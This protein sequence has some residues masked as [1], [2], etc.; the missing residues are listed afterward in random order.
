MRAQRTHDRIYSV[1]VDLF[2]Y[3][4]YGGSSLRD[5]AEIAGINVATIYHHYASKLAI[6][7]DIIEVTLTDLADGGR[8]A[9]KQS[10]GPSASLVALARWHT[11]FHC[12][13][14]QEATITDREIN[15]VPINVRAREVAIR[16]SYEEMWRR[17]IAIGVKTSEFV[18]DDPDVSRFAVLT[19]CS[20]VAAWYNANGRLTPDE[21]ADIYGDLAL[22]LVGS[23]HVHDRRR[24][25]AQIL[26]RTPR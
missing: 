13:R 16:D 14:A 10:S 15:S 24:V 25:A 5:L 2:Y 17:V 21:I 12:I 6:L 22:R 18:V 9:L 1:A 23:S 3:H 11:S 26:P 19:M 8:R 7:Q 20:Q 4:G